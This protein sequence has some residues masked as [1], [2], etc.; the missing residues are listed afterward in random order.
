MISTGQGAKRRHHLPGRKGSD[1]ITDPT[2][3]K[4]TKNA[5]MTLCQK[6]IENRNKMDKFF[7]GRKK[8]LPKWHKKKYKIWI[9]LYL[10]KQ[11]HL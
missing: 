1:I 8:N 2:I 6:K 11:H 10:L 5:K 9:Y 4:M 3:V 7:G